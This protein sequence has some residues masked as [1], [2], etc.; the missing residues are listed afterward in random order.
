MRSAAGG[1]SNRQAGRA[2]SLQKIKKYPVNVIAPGLR[3]LFVGINPGPV[4]PPPLATTII[5]RAPVNRFWACPARRRLQLSPASIPFRRQ[6]EPPPG[7][8]TASPNLVKTRATAQRP[9][10]LDPS[11]FIAGRKQPQRQRSENNPADARG[12]FSGVGAYCHAFGPPRRRRSASKP[13]SFEGAQVWVLTQPQRAYNANYQTFPALNQA[14]PAPSRVGG[15]K[16]DEIENRR[17]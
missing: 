4:T 6:R 16:R 17:P 12:L 7:R 2:S 13:I 10:E 11:E 9:D 5:S 8:A 3:V 15:K 14:L 1:S